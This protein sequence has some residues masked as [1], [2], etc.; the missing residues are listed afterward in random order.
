MANP[1]E[2]E[3]IEPFWYEGRAENGIP[4]CTICGS[5][6]QPKNPYYTKD[7][8]T[9]AVL[10]RDPSIDFRCFPSLSSLPPSLLS[11]ERQITRHRAEALAFTCFKLWDDDEKGKVVMANQTGGE[12]HAELFICMHEACM[13]IVD[14]FLALG[15]IAPPPLPTKPWSLSMIWD[16]VRLRI[17][18]GQRTEY[19]GAMDEVMDV[20]HP[21]DYFALTGHHLPFFQSCGLWEDPLEV[22]LD[23][24]SITSS[25]R[26]AKIDDYQNDD[27]PARAVARLRQG[28]VSLP[29]ELQDYILD[30]IAPGADVGIHCNRILSSGTWRSLLIEGRLTP[31]LWEIDPSKLPDAESVDY[32][33]MVRQLSQADI[34]EADLHEATGYIL[35]S[36][37]L[38]NRRRIWRVLESM[39]AGDLPTERPWQTLSIFR[40]EEE[41]KENA[42][43]V[44][45]W[46]E[47][48]GPGGSHQNV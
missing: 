4:A 44:K 36:A 39:R 18:V 25:W 10:I 45:E 37:G 24:S 32:E 23:F 12:F 16:V 19:V 38:W 26:Q 31:W 27:T 43:Y 42:E 30:F 17:E 47:E 41:E 40:N 33:A 28:Y 48:W 8:D 46:C 13:E 22:E 3:V 14:Q 21:H 9:R 2:F 1:T 35:G 29:Q 11:Q 5:P 20:D 34:L 15:Y 7:W 6:I